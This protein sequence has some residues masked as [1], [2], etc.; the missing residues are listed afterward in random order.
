MDSS[1]EHS[2]KRPHP[3][4]VAVNVADVDVAAQLASSN[5]NLDPEAAAKL[6]FVRFTVLTARVSNNVPLDER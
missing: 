5:V 1:S 4:S 2:E 6:R 3:G